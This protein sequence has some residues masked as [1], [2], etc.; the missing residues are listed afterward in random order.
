MTQPG[1]AEIVPGGA[2]G[3]FQPQPFHDSPVAEGFSSIPWDFLGS[4]VHSLSVDPQVPPLPPSLATSSQNLQR[5]RFFL[6]PKPQFLFR[7][8]LFL[9]TQNVPIK[10]EAKTSR[11]WGFFKIQK[12]LQQQQK[13]TRGIFSEATAPRFLGQLSFRGKHPKKLIS[14]RLSLDFGGDTKPNRDP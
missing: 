13:N 2:L 8:G 5:K 14:H 4:S 10:E 9:P 7:P 11:V 12:P 1:I 6:P 3:S